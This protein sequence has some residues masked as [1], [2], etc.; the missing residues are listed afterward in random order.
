MIVII[1]METRIYFLDRFIHIKYI[2]LG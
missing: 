2:F 1:Y